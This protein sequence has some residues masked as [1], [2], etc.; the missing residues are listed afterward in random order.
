M[1]AKEEASRLTIGELKKRLSN[2]PDDWQITF[3][4]NRN[5]ELLVFYRTKPRGE[6]LLQIELNE[7][8]EDQ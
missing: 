1:H 4:S 5:G 6:K 3:G 7:L 2:Y 8:T